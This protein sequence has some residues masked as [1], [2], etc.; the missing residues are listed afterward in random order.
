LLGN[1]FQLF[2]VHKVRKFLADE[3]LIFVERNLDVFKNDVQKVASDLRNIFLAD[4]G[5]FMSLHLS[6]GDFHLVYSPF[7]VLMSLLEG[8]NQGDDRADSFVLGVLIFQ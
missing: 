4:F 6:V 5:A 8:V 1:V 7:M 3:L 2:K